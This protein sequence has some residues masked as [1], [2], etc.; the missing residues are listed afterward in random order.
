MGPSKIVPILALLC[1]ITI[2][3]CGNA[4]ESESGPSDFSEFNTFEFSRTSALGEPP[5]NRVVSAMIERDTGGDYDLSLSVLRVGNPDLDDCSEPRFDGL[6]PVTVV[7]EAGLLSDDEASSMLALFGSVETVDEPDACEDADVDPV[8]L[9]HFAWK[10]GGEY[11]DFICDAIRLDPIYANKLLAFLEGL[12]EPPEH[13]CDL[14]QCFRAIQCVERCGGP[15]RSSGC[16]PCPEGQF[17]DLDC[18]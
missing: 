17:D 9:N 18:R 11:G 1:C 7:E 10:P 13:A 4:G 2:S 12:R 6:C 5:I 16:C 15:V 3:A 14:F 8:Y